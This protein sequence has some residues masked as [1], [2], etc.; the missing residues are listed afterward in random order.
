LC[1]AQ[2]RARVQEALASNGS[3]VVTATGIASLLGSQPT[4]ELLESARK[5]FRAVRLDMLLERHLDTSVPSAECFAV[6]TSSSLGR[7][8]IRACDA[9]P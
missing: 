1:R 8:A 7:C 6:S 3:G 4:H 5:S 9:R 2:L